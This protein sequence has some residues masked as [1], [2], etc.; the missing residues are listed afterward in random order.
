[1]CGTGTAP[2]TPAVTV[3]TVSKIDRESVIFVI[4][5]RHTVMV[6]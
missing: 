5:A 4:W 6:L 2:R 3:Q 1:V